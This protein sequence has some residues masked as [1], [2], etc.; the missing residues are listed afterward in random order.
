MGE[1]FRNR[2]KRRRR[3]AALTTPLQMMEGGPGVV[4]FGCWLFARD[5]LHFQRADI[6]PC[7][8]RKI[9]I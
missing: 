9:V 2:D 4:V 6:S 3:G 1:A 8:L 7:S 5:K